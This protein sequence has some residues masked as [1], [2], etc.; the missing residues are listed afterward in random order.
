MVPFSVPLHL[1][2]LSCGLVRGEVSVSIGPQLPVE[3]VHMILGNDLA[4]D[5]VWAVGVPNVVKPPVSSSVVAP[6]AR[7]QGSDNIFPK[8]LVVEGHNVDLKRAI[9]W[10]VA[11]NPDILANV[12]KVFVGGVRNHIKADNL[13]KYFSEFG[14]VEKAVI[15]SDKQTGRKRGFGFV[16]KDTDSVTKAMLTKYHVIN[17]N[18]VEVKKALARQEVSTGGCKRGRRKGIHG[19]GRGYGGYDE[20]GYPNQRLMRW[21]QICVMQQCV[22]SISLVKVE[23]YCI[24][25]YFI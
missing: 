13:T 24:F 3:G 18:K 15:I 12:K 9:A 20:G 17:G 22:S 6:S 5:K 11:N 19:Y 7:P 10:D 25:N 2:S 1:V 21:S 23:L 4:G 16:F 8:P 14:V